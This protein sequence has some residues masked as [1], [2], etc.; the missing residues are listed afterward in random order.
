MVNFLLERKTG[1]AY[2]NC[3]HHAHNLRRPP[4][5]A[6]KIIQIFCLVLNAFAFNTSRSFT[7][8]PFPDK[9]LIKTYSLFNFLLER[10]TGLAYYNCSHHAH[11]LRRPPSLAQ[12]IIQIFCLVLN[13]FA[14]N[15]SRSFTSSPFPDKKLIKTYS[16]FN[17]LL[18]R[19]TGLEPATLS[20]EG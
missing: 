11:N 13:A 2:Y 4:S 9:K 18:E 19:K 3:S 1:L 14:F 7:S 16:L 8:S 10:K 12:K 15:T 17:F 5:L 6:Q 20:L